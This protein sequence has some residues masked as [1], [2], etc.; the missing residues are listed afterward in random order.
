MISKVA[1]RFFGLL[2]FASG[3]FAAEIPDYPFVF[4]VG[5]ADI[6]TPPNIATCS[7]TL[8]AREPDADKAASVVEDRLKA[9]LTTLKTNHI[10]P[11]DIESFSIQKQIL[12]NENDYNEPI[13]RG[14]EVSR[15]LKFTARQLESVAPVEGSLVKAANMVDISCQFDRTDRAAMEGELLTKALHR[16]REEADKLAEPLGRHVIAAVAISKAPFDSLGASFGFSDSPGAMAKFDRM[17]KRSV[18]PGVLRGEDLLVP[19]T[20][21][22]SVSVNAL[23]KME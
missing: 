20:I 16:A 2:L 11:G 6:E 9:V 10:P 18:D 21:H 13:I 12:T 4:V 14:Y 17:F 15:S 1:Y 23:F 8:R 19:A 3:A 7:L 22:M 5:K